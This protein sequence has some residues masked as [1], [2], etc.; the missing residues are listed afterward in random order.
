MSRIGRMP[1]AIPAGVKVTLDGV[2]IVVE[3]PKGKLERDLHPVAKF[4]D[5]HFLPWKGKNFL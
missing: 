2:H 3:G 1:V 5:C 4:M